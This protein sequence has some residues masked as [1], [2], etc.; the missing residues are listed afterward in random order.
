MLATLG[1]LI[2]TIIIVLYELSMHSV[3]SVQYTYF[4][5]FSSTSSY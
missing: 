4:V 3:W 1:V 5:I 2:I